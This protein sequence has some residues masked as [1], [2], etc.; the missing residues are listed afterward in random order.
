MAN[1]ICIIIF[2]ITGLA[3]AQYIGGSEDGSD[4]STLTGSRLNGE[5]ASFSVLY[6]GSSGDG[7]DA[8]NN[9]LVLSN[10]PFELYYGSSG[11][12][13]SQ[14][15]V[16][17]TLSGSNI[18]NLYDGNSGDGFSQKNHQ[19]ILSGRDLAILFSGNSSDGFDNEIAYNQLLE[20][21]ISIIF[22]G[23]I[24][25][26]FAVNNYTT[27]LTLD[28]VEQLIKMD[29]LLYPNPASQIV[30][31][32]TNDNIVITSVE[33]YDISGKKIGMELSNENSLDVSNLADGIY[34]L[35][36]FSESGGVRKRL[37]IKK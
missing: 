37:I 20:G 27:A 22:K 34:L 29:V 3:N 5:I 18:N 30:T 17:L 10:L 14:K 15:L 33:V 13:F 25:D 35:N 4:Q 31:I 9:Q 23:G 24:G 21:F 8:Q 32:K 11:D 36:I 6:Q 28:I 7:F 2:L 19:T 16:A 1:K 26:G 12:G